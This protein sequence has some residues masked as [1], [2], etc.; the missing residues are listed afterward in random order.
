M[1]QFY[2]RHGTALSE[3]DNARVDIGARG[4]S[5]FLSRDENC[6]RCGGA[7]GSAHWRPDGG[8]CYQC[9]GNRTV[10]VTHR[11]FTEAKLAKLNESYAVR[12]AK[13]LAEREAAEEKRFIE[14]VQWGRDHKKL[15]G[16]IAAATGSSFLASLDAQL[17]G[18]KI[19]TERQLEAAANAI[20]GQQVRKVEGLASEYV[21]EVKDRIEFEAE[22][23]GVYGTEGYYGHTDIV[24]FKDARGNYFTW[25][26]SDYT[27]LACGD[28]MS[29]KGTVKKHDQFRGIKQTVLT[30]CKYTKFAIMTPDEAAQ[31]E[32]V[33]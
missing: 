31:M 20:E 6:P 13:R 8:V 19:L 9:H 22:V 33:A 23:I 18:N 4:E 5:G 11:V 15:L 17:K 3:K 2:F 25:F 12:E 29:I 7:G 1:T 28:R 32:A 10:P 14:F 24:K 21:G 27:N 16:A 26:A 30:R